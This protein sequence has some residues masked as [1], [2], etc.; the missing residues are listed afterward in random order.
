M[1]GKPTAERLT[2]NREPALEAG[3]GGDS[4]GVTDGSTVSRTAAVDS[5]G[6]N[7]G[8]IGGDSSFSAAPSTRECG[9]VKQAAASTPETAGSSG[10]EFALPAMSLALVLVLVMSMSV[11]LMLMS[12]SVSITE[13][14]SLIESSPQP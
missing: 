3:G 10:T 8:G 12:W 9:G 6:S 4:L 5:V 11:F 7:T 13:S 14:E 1:A 2:L